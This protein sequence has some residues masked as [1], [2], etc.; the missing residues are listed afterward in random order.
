VQIEAGRLT[1]RFLTMRKIAAALDTEPSEIEEF[2]AA[3][4]QA[5]EGKE[6]AAA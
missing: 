4:K 5:S 1:P 3:I 2:A 6:P